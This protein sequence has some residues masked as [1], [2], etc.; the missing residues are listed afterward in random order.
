LEVYQKTFS[1]TPRVDRNCC[2]RRNFAFSLLSGKAGF[3]SINNLLV[4]S[5][6]LHRRNRNAF[7]GSRSRRMCP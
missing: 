2:H 7:T 5:L 4:K 3:A 1:F 6:W